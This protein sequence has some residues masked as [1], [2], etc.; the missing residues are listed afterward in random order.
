MQ[1]VIVLNGNNQFRKYQV[2][3]CISFR[4]TSEQFGGLSNMAPNYTIEINN[5]RILTS[6]ALYQACRFPDNIEIQKLIISQRSPMTAK[7]ISKK[8][9]ELTRSDW[10]S[11]RIKIM[12]WCLRAKLIF[13][14]YTFGE[15]LELTGEKIIVEDSGK[16]M[17]WGAKRNDGYF[18]GVNALGRLLMQ[19]RE[20]YIHLKDNEKIRLEPLDIPNFKF[21]GEPIK[22][23]TVN[24]KDQLIGINETLW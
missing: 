9:I 4:K 12:R 8:Y 6:E 24:V 15:L 10:D 3:D 13:N 7:D 21:M 23:I 22:Q 5:V 18:E 2:K 16:D 20:Q 14:W 19:L 11:E 1:V 17:F